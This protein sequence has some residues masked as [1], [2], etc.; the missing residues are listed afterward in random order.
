MIAMSI[1]M[2]TIRHTPRP[3]SIAYVLTTF[4]D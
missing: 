1:D 2:A 4:N 3:A